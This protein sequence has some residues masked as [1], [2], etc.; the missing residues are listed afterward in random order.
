[1]QNKRN[2]YSFLLA[3]LFVSILGIT[4]C[5][6]DEP[7]DGGEILSNEVSLS[8]SGSL[9]VTEKD[10]T[11]VLTYNFIIA[12]REA[13]S[14]I[15]NAT[16]EDLSHGVNYTTSP[17]ESSGVITIPFDAAATSVTLQIAVNDDSDNLPNGKVTFTLA[18]VTGENSSVT[19]SSSS[20]ELTILDNEG[21][22]IV[23]TSDEA[24]ALGEAV[25]GQAQME[26]VEITFTSLN[27][28]TAIDAEATSG[29]VIGATADGEFTAN[30]ALA[31][32]ATSF[33]V[34]A[35]P[36][37][38]AAFGAL[39]GT[40]T[41]SSGEA[42]AVFSFE[43]IVSNAIGELF[44]AEYFDYPINETYPTYGDAG[45]TGAIVPVS[46]R[47][48][49]AG[50]YNGA[51]GSVDKITGLQR[52]GVF[53]TW[54]IQQRMAG[55][56]MGDNPLSF[57]GY[58]NSGIGRTAKLALDGSNQRQ[59]NDCNTESKN[60]AIARRFAE[61]GSEIT[62]GSVYFSAMVNVLEVQDETVPVMKNAIMMLTGDV[63]FVNVNA[64]KLNVIDD[65]A[66]GYHFGVSKSSDD[67]SVVYG[68]TSYALGTT[69]AVVFKVK[70]NE[71]LE[72]EDPN[73]VV[74]VYVFEEGSTIPS[75][76]DSSLTPEARIDVTNQEADVHDVT[77]GLEI[78][79]MREVADAFSAGGL[80]NVHV[81]SVEFSGLRIATSWN[82]LFKDMSEALY[83]N[84][85]E[86][87]LQGIRY[88]NANCSGFPGGN[89][90]NTDL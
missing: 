21:E 68:T 86:D 2:A 60:A 89:L 8:D 73:D 36:D 14:L 45:F 46:A 90:G 56:A 28:I 18:E 83:D 54:Y 39:T 1:M 78:F 53:D 58:P 48:R 55:I 69:Y 6:T 26:A 85:S 17:A 61:E 70:I 66:G 43:A 20:F 65:G 75:F 64:M 19:A 49:L 37:A 63:S 11:I 81:Q 7:D 40:V 16:V 10:T 82:A 22:S 3:F 57:T 23:P 32:D 15:V 77:S 34:K 31:M 74:S 50:A 67:G 84:T 35:S 29:F 9:T 38:T 42:T 47:Y 88:G 13:G 72:G 44:W 25:P 4:S 87:A 71:D 51:D 24:L 5:G 62:T 76:E 79:F 12:T 30:L 59:R 27:I 52:L 33:F 80:A 41:L